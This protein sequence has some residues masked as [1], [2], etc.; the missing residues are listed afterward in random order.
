MHRR[1]IDRLDSRR[2]YWVP[3]VV[4]PYRNWAGAPGCRRGGR[5]MVNPQT[6]RASREEFD[7]FDS[8][9]SCLR[10]IMQHRLQLNRA[11]PGASVRAVRLD[12]WLL[13][14]A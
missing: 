12:Q 2:T 6:F 10:W 13:G 5:F 3:I 9:L 14:L 8:E 11:L 1:D 7:T 4:S